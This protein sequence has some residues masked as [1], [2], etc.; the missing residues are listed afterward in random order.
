MNS[1]NS[2]FNMMTDDD[3]VQLTNLY[4]ITFVAINRCL[5]SSIIIFREHESNDLGHAE[6]S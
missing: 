3:N 6:C 4:Y 2:Q 1:F 5:F